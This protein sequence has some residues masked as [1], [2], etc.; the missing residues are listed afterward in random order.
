MSAYIVFPSNW[1]NLWKDLFG[2]SAKTG[3]KHSDREKSAEIR[4][5][6]RDCLRDMIWSNPESFAGELDVHVLACKF[7]GKL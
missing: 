4:R 7:H 1:M 2:P 5:A 6:E 3:A